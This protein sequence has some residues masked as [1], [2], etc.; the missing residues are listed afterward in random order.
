MAA[1]TA[2]HAE[3][4][5]SGAQPLWNQRENYLMDVIVEFRADGCITWREGKE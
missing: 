3:I 2:S 1:G 4:V 5:A